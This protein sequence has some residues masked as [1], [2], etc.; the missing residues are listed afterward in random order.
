MSKLFPEFTQ[1][2]LKPKELF[3]HMV[4]LFLLM[5]ELYLKARKLLRMYCIYKE[6]GMFP[7]KMEELLNCSFR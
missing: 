6:G 5:V 3:W 7:L 1:L 4:E 2:L